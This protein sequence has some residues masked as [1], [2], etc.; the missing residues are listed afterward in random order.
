MLREDGGPRG[1]AQR[2]L[3]EKAGTT[4]GEIDLKVPK[5]RGARFQTAV[6]E[7]FHRR[8]T[9]VKEA[10]DE[11]RLAGISTR[12]IEDVSEIPWGAPVFSGTVSNLN[13]KAFASIEA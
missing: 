6:I 5:L 11:M 1:L 12:R 13:E 9:S 8:E 2:A 3:Q 4:G 7:H 10:I